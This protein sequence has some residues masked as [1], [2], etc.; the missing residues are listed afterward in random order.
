M[1]IAL[2]SL[3][4]EA[5]ATGGG[6]VH[7]KNICDQLLGL[8]Q[9]I[10][11]VSIHTEKTLPHAEL[12]EWD[13]PLSVEDRGDL[14]VVR[15]LIDRGI[16][17]PYVG[18]KDTE[19]DRIKRFSDT[20]IKWLKQNLE[21][22][23]VINL[24]GHHMLPGYMARELQ[25]L[26]PK[27]ISYIHALETTYVTKKGDFVGAYDGTAEVLG[28]IREWEAMCR[29]P[30]RIFVNSPQVRDELLEI[31]EEFVE[32]SA[33]YIDKIVL[34]SS[35]CNKGF[36]LSDGTIG[37]KL[38]VVPEV[39]ELVTFCRIDPS[40]GIHYSIQGAKEA[41]KQSSRRFRLTIAGIPAS[42]EYVRTLRKDTESLPEN[43]EVEF[44]LFDAISPTEE[45]QELLDPKHIYIL[46]TLKEPFGMSIIEASARGNMIVSADTNGPKF[47]MEMESGKDLEWGIATRYGALA[48]ITDDHE[49]NFA[50]NVGSAIAWT[51]DNWTACAE[52]VLAFNEK[53]RNTWT[54]ESIG[55]QYLAIFEAT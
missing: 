16:A 35:G 42:E 39:V 41:A 14:R 45:K 10:T 23:D 31:V 50:H 34:L 55:E 29:F 27:V 33:P 6:G 5:T 47:M 32:S 12:K 24:H 19:L 21:E 38:S 28:R 17:Q 9:K 25:G 36:L 51:V 22:F 30:D 43:L 2:V 40:K 48:R 11:I 15:F 46:P 3:Q 4:F 49:A 26:G 7:V 52:N 1:R 54:W 8:G 18:D 37:E 44:R 53:V 13:V 20:A